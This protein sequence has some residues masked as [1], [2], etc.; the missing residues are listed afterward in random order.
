MEYLLLKILIEVWESSVLDNNTNFFPLHFI[1]VNGLWRGKSKRGE[2]K[3][4]G[5]NG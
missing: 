5:S 3:T 1:K 2:W 4:L